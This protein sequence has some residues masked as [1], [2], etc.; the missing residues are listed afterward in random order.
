[1]ELFGAIKTISI[2]FLLFF[3]F[4]NMSS[5]TSFP[6]FP[7]FP[8]TPNLPYLPTL[9]TFPVIK[10]S[11]DRGTLDNTTPVSLFVCL[12]FPF[13]EVVRFFINYI[14]EN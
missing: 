8:T 3:Y 11:P 9:P 1:M 13:R 10:E 2:L 12:F 14:K 6:I 5:F 7:T 4:S